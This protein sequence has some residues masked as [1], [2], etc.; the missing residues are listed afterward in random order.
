M[1]TVTILKALAEGVDPH[2][3]KAFP[4]DSAYQHPA[5]VRALYRAIEVLGHGTAVPATAPIAAK[6][7]R[8]VPSNAGKPWSEDDDT[9]LINAFD[10]GESV[11]AIAL[12]HGRSRFAIEAR[13][14]RF[15]RVP[16]PAGL[17]QPAAPATATAAHA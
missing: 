16:M 8:P 11:T 1:D 12:A 7:P 17:R 14:A 2:S 3:G 5:T 13:L 15:N 9:R 10:A 6:P 4:A